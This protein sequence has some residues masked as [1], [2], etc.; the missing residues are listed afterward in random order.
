MT[1]VRVHHLITGGNMRLNIIVAEPIGQSIV[2]AGGNRQISCASQSLGTWLANIAGSLGAAEI[3]EVIA[4]L[5]FK[6]D[7]KSHPLLWKESVGLK[8]LPL[9]RE[10]ATFGSVLCH[11]IQD[12]KWHPGELVKCDNLEDFLAILLWE[13]VPISERFTPELLPGER[14]CLICGRRNLGE[15]EGMANMSGGYDMYSFPEY[16]EWP[17]CF[18]HFLENQVNLAYRPDFIAHNKRV[19]EDEEQLNADFEAFKARQ[20]AKTRA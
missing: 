4:L 12:G 3:S 15:S 11:S 2:L 18:S 20:L 6:R 16:C 13:A 17:D 7:N 19:V 8:E 14:Y 5:D 1:E 10:I 9:S